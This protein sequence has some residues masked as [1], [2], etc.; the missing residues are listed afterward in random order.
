VL[1]FRSLYPSL[2]R[3]FRI[4][5]L[6][7]LRTGPNGAGGRKSGEGATAP[8]GHDERARPS[9][10]EAPDGQERAGPD[11]ESPIRA[12]NGARFA[13]TGGILPELL[14]RLF[15]LR[16]QALAQ[17]DPLTATALKLLMNS[18]YG[19][20]A[21][22]R[23]RF[24]SPET[25]NAITSFGQQ[26][27][28]FSCEAIEARGRR[29]LYGDTDSIFVETGVKESPAAGEIGARLAAEINAALTARLRAEHGVE[30]RLH[31]RFDRLFRRLF[32]PG[33][34]GSAE[35]SKK[36]YAGLTGEGAEERILFVG[37]ESVRRDWTDLAKRFQ[38]ELLARVFRDEPVD[39]Y[40]RNFLARLRAGEFDQ[41]LVYRKALRKPEAA[42]TRTT[43]PHVQAAR[44]LTQKATRIMRYVVTTAGPEPESERTHPLDREHYAEKQVRPVAEA[45]LAL[46]GLSWEEVTGGQGTLGF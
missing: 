35:G 46:L 26:T 21:T 24:Y 23:C 25:A 39:G 3:T 9:G 2:I 30:S 44:Q 36:R 41:L 8:A 14:D 33:L 31:L 40:V 20:L 22:P 11:A 45:V 17:G 1:D 29:V 28:L 12:P 15:P 42:Y 34:R 5:P 13:R 6:T 18:F 19:V 32:L 4:D 10:Q 7:L 37:L 38:R 16:E 43:P 27:L